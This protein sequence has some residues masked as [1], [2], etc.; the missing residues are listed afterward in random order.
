MRKGVTCPKC[1]SRSA[2]VYSVVNRKESIVRVRKCMGCKHKF[3]TREVIVSN[4]IEQNLLPVND[5]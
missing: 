2:R 5:K 1:K 3:V 4:H